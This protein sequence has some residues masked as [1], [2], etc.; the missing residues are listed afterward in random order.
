MA[1]KKREKEM[2]RGERERECLFEGEKNLSVGSLI[3][4]KSMERLNGIARSSLSFS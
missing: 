4:A 2:G 3:G 1:R